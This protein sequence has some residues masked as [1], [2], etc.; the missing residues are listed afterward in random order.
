ML[1]AVDAALSAHEAFD[2]F[3]EDLRRYDGFKPIVNA[4]EELRELEWELTNCD[5]TNFYYVSTI[6]KLNEAGEEALHNQL[7]I[8]RM[9]FKKWKRLKGVEQTNGRTL[10]SEISAHAR[11]KSLDSHRR[12][13]VYLRN[14]DSAHS[15]TSAPEEAALLANRNGISDTLVTGFIHLQT[16][17]LLHLKLLKELYIN[18]V[19]SK[20][21]GLKPPL[22]WQSL[23]NLLRDEA[24]FTAE[25][26]YDGF[27]K[28]S[29]DANE[30]PQPSYKD[31]YKTPQ[32]F[33]IYGSPATATDRD[34]LYGE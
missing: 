2:T 29:R 16:S 9:G 32:V 27:E 28:S 26:G 33:E 6:A 20:L 18:D 12:S 5:S 1:N 22:S 15:T 19:K 13:C 7:E 3:V 31:A 23:D 34:S 10:L 14:K 24:V 25:P 30:V 17:S 4:F 8:D 21:R 11:R